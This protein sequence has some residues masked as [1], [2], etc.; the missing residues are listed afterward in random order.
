MPK[1][2]TKKEMGVLSQYPDLLVFLGN[3]NGAGFFLEADMN[4]MRK[5]IVSVFKNNPR[6]KELFRECLNESSG[7]ITMPH[8]NGKLR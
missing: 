3:E 4:R 7:I 8:L 5:G 1:Q 2:P 6:V